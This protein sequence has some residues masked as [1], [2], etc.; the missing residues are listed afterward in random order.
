[1][2]RIQRVLPKRSTETEHAYILRLFNYASGRV[3]HC[4]LM[5]SL[6]RIEHNPG[7]AHFYQLE[8]ATWHRRMCEY[9]EC[10]ENDFF[11][12]T[13]TPI[14]VI[15]PADEWDRLNNCLRGS[16]SKQFIV[17]DL[18]PPK[19]TETNRHFVIDPAKSREAGQT[20]VISAFNKIV[21]RTLRY[22]EWKSSKYSPI[23]IEPVDGAV[24]VVNIDGSIDYVK[25]PR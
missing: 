4:Y 3:D 16:R 1:M 2:T 22:P 14:D 12:G 6:R 19:F 15:F 20:V 7:A 5:Q 18:S 11:P 9:R 17:D 21:F 10:L 13:V 8:A 24:K 23:K 25:G